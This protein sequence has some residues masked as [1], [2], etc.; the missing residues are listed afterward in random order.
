MNPFTKAYKNLINFIYPLRCLVCG[1]DLHPYDSNYICDEHRRQIRIIDKPFCEKCGKKMYGRTVEELTCDECKTTKRNFDRAF[2]ATE[3]NE[4]MRQLIHQ[5]KYNRKEY[6]KNSF[7]QMMFSFINKYVDISQIDFI[8]PVPLHW[9]RYKWRGFNQ[10]AE[11]SKIISK[12][13]KISIIKRNL[14]R[15]RFTTPQ[16][17]VPREERKKNIK[18]AFEVMV[19]KEIKGKNILLV[20]DFFTTGATA[21][22]C[23]RALKKAGAVQ[24]QVF[25]LSQAS[26]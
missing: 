15:K 8:I 25:A 2:S 7:S 17:F 20:D 9:R 16:V 10:A 14:R 18:D 22:E 21:D 6:L 12:K 1:K 5:Y 26:I 19:K 4:V 3:N 23:A 13:Y 11:L 24:V